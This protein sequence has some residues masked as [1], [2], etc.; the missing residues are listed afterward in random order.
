RTV[1]GRADLACVEGAVV[2]RVVPGQP[3]LVT[4]LPPERHHPLHRFDRAPA[5]QDDLLA[6]TVRL[7]AAERPEERIAPPGAVAQRAAEAL[8]DGTA[9]LLQRRADLPIILELR[10]GLGHAHF[11]EPRLP[12]GDEAGQDPVR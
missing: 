2:I 8:A 7:G 9:G 3:A 4:R 11:G 1:E 6:R 12:V 10:R 5:A